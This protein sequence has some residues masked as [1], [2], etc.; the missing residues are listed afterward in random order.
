MA[1]AIANVELTNS[2]DQW[3]ITTNQ[4]IDALNN[5]VVTKEDF[6]IEN[7]LDSVEVNAQPLSLIANPEDEKTPSDTLVLKAPLSNSDKIANFKA[8]QKVR[9]YGAILNNSIYTAAETPSIIPIPEK[10]GFA[11]GGTSTFS[12]RIAQ[13]D[14]LTGKVS[15]A[16]PVD[17]D[18]TVNGIDLKGFNNSN[19]IELNIVKSNANYGVLIY[20]QI[21]GTGPEDINQP[22]YY[23]V[24]VLGPY[25]IASTAGSWKDLF[26]VDS[27]IWS[28]K[29]V[30]NE[31]V[32]TT[33]TIHF[34]LTVPSYP[35][36][37]WI[38][39]EVKFVDTSLKRLTFLDTFLFENDCV[40]SHDDTALIQDTIDE[41]NSIGIKSLELPT[42]TYIVKGLVIPD[43]FSIIGKGSKTTLKKLS[44]SSNFSTTGN[45][46][47]KSD[48]SIQN[49]SLSD[50]VLDGNMQNQY[51]ISEVVDGNS[52]YLVDVVGTPDSG[53]FRYENIKLNNAIG[54]GI[55]AA[56][57]NSISVISSFIVDSNL[58]DRDNFV[59]LN[60]DS[61]SDVVLSSNLFRNFSGPVS[62]S[63]LTTG[64]IVGN[65]IKNC[66]T[67]LLIFGSTNLISSPNILMGPSNEF[68]PSADVLNSE[69]DSVNIK[70]DQDLNFVSTLYTYQ[71]NGETINLSPNGPNRVTIHHRVDRLQ[72]ANNIESLYGEEI[73]INSLRP[74]QNVPDTN[75]A[76]G[77]FRFS[78][79]NTNVNVL[80][81]TY[82]YNNLVLTNPNH[83][84]LIYR[85][86]ATEYVPS[87]TINPSE[88]ANP[89]STRE[90]PT[91]W[92]ISRTINANTSGVNNTA[93]T[94]KIDNVVTGQANVNNIGQNYFKVGDLVYYNLPSTNTAISGLT[95]NT[96]YYVTFANNTDIALSSTY[97][98]ANI[99]LNETRIANPS[100]VHNLNKTAYVAKI[101]NITNMYVGA[102]VRFKDHG[103]DPNLNNLVGT[104]VSFS[105]VTGICEFYY[106]PTIN[107]VAAGSN[108]TITVENSY[109]L[110]KGRIL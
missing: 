87:G 3:R 96:K 60:V 9:I 79:S 11:G 107:I 100:E 20:R 94:L 108:G 95:A 85:S 45:R 18:A 13:F 58:N 8:G 103:G 55:N 86:I 51:L 38:E 35:R 56:N 59:P 47:I 2:F 15:A 66:G 68:L 73:L 25:D 21:T 63:T 1:I 54:S 102:K 30:R 49:F 61:S 81:N 83:V 74:I 7:V 106:D 89:P 6:F 82:S 44:W 69:Y 37:G 12:Y 17:P 33:G 78:I 19:N 29:N 10:V 23:L 4:M 97:G 16:T 48:G 91:V 14:Y 40:V 34:P 76:N 105:N 88:N 71:E 32:S 101:N 62:A 109:V 43:N 28:K 80:L 22:D 46:L 31:Y 64:S 27:V 39:T 57:S 110:A 92:N 67:G 42:K 104:V 36:Q 72:K 77:V 53:N 26:D 84:G 65:I 24:A 99:N 75:L 90:I 70:L 41:R 98:G 5:Q 50:V 93:D 52:N